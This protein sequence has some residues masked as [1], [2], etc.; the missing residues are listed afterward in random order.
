MDY[1]I[2]EY[3]TDKTSWEVPVA[4]FFGFRDLLVNQK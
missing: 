1:L 3:Y 4:F 2:S